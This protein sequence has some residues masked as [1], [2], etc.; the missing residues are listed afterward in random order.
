LASGGGRVLLCAGA[1]T[2]RLLMQYRE[3]P[4]NEAIGKD[5]NNHVAMPLGFCVK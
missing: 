1:A 3:N 5:S 4:Q 2:P